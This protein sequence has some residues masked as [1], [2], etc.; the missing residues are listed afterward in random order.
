MDKGAGD[1]T[2]S[3]MNSVATLRTSD[4]LDR[5]GNPAE[6]ES[7]TL[8]DLLHEFRQRAFGAL[9]LVALL[10]TFLPAPGIGAFTGPFVALAGLQL[11]LTFQQPWLPKWIARRPVK[12]STV[13]R[14]GKRF[15]PILARIER[16]CKPRLT[17]VIEN[18]AAQSFTGL[19]LLLLGLLLSLPLP[20]TNYPLGVILLFYCIALIERDGVLMLIGWLLGIA[21]I[22]ASVVLSNEVVALIAKLWT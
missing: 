22:I 15:R 20:G 12:R 14:F 3:P 7:V 16:I 8:G 18:V 13:Q 4:L 17:G 5:I 6:G 19:Q 21:A 9:L 10:L 1:D 2:A 11:L